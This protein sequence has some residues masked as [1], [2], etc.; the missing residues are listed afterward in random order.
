MLLLL[1]RPCARRAGDGWTGGGKRLSGRRKAGREVLIRL[2]WHCLNVKFSLSSP[3]SPSSSLS[4]SPPLTVRA[5]G[6]KMLH[7]PPPP[8]P[9]SRRRRRRR[10]VAT[11]QGLTDEEEEGKKHK[12]MG[13]RG[14]GRKVDG[15]NPRFLSTT[16]QCFFFQNSRKG[17]DPSLPCP[18]TFSVI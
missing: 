17:F 5:G 11:P 4:F 9:H 16:L 2:S 10:R 12:K 1:L 3:P 18:P 15:T 14:H 6:R 13:G 7:S 8:P